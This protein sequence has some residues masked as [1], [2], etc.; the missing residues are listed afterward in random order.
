M[1]YLRLMFI[2]TLHTLP[3]ACSCHTMFTAT[4]LFCW[5][6]LDDANVATHRWNDIPAT[7]ND[8][9]PVATGVMK[10]YLQI[11]PTTSYYDQKMGSSINQ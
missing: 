10:A 5:V 8:G 7:G 2:H 1:M 4:C 11:F 9:L 6:R 3:P